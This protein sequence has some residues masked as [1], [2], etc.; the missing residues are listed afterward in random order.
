LATLVYLAV[1]LRHANQ[2][3]E[4]EALRYT[5]DALNQFCGSLSQSMEIA[6]IVNRGRVCLDDLNQDEQLVFEHLHL[7]MLNTLESWYLQVNQTTKPGENL[8]V[9]I[10]NI[11]N[12][13]ELYI[14]FPGTRAVWSKYRRAYVPIHGLVD[15]N[16]SKEP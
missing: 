8:D 10:G 5:W 9:Q 1:Q 16:I 15:D 6:S 7:R 14:D 13:I 2:Q 11:A 12:I 4:L 3:R